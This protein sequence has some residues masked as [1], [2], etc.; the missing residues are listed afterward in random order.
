MKQTELQR[1]RDAI[2]GDTAMTTCNREAG[3]FSRLWGRECWIADSV[4][5]LIQ[6][7]IDEEMDKHA[8]NDPLYRV[9]L[10]CEELKEKNRIGNFPTAID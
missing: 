8:P 7:S 10:Y 2:Q 3:S 4:L 1:V 6:S 5:S 9:W